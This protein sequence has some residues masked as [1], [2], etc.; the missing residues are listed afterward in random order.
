MYSLAVVEYG[1]ADLDG[2]A[3]GA[4]EAVPGGVGGRAGVRLECDVG[5][6][7]GRGRPR[8]RG[9]PRGTSLCNGRGFRLAFGASASRRR[10][11]GRGGRSGG[12][13]GARSYGR[14]AGVMVGVVEV[15]VVVMVVAVIVVVTEK[16]D[17]V[18]L[19]K[20]RKKQNKKKSRNAGRGK[21]GCLRKREEA[22][23]RNGEK[24]ARITKV[25]GLV[26]KKMEETDKTKLRKKKC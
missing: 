14:E 19:G 22:N 10:R 12:G 6:H 1:L 15:V 26:R 24:E 4:V 8:L 20:G 16:I 11:G 17:W 25:M 18:V 7:R 9:R 13:E 5:P 3:G 21:K 23:K 2:E